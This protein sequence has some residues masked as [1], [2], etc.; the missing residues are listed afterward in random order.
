MSRNSLLGTSIALACALAGC[1]GTS[2]SSSAAAQRAGLPSGSRLTQ[3]YRVKL[4]G[5]AATPRGAPQGIGAAIIAFHGDSLVCWRFA[6]LHGFIDAASAQVHVGSAGHLG[7]IALALSTGPHLHH[8][9]CVRVNPTLTRKI[10]SDPSGYY[11]DIPSKQY[12][13]GAARGQL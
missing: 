11:V 3:V 6:H 10:G 5:A 8:Q 2:S 7:N 12:P 13:Q 4:T 1:G 9:G